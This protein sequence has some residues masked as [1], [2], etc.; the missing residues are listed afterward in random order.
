MTAKTVVDIL[1][2]LVVG[3]FCRKKCSWLDKFLRL[4][5]QLDELFLRKQFI[6]VIL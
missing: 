2:M 1:E 5:V 3:M 4:S 6:E